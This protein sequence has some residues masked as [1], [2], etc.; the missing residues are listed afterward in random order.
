MGASRAPFGKDL[1]RSGVSFGRSWALLGRFFNVQNRTF[2]KHW[3][4][5]VST[6]PLGSILGR[7]WEDLGRF[8]EAKMNLT[9]D[10]WE[11]CFE[12]SFERNLDVDYGRFLEAPNQ[13]NS[14]F[15]NGKS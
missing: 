3:S 7:F 8:G 12:F 14:N 6:R 9:V 13:K 4:R 15:L 5:M 2:V 11:V 1:G 10:F